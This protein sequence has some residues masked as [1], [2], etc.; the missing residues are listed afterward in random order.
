MDRLITNDQFD[1]FRNIGQFV[2]TEIVEGR[3]ETRV[4]EEG[5]KEN[6]GNF[7]FQRATI[8]VD[9]RW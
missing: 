7:L 6:A 2:V 5:F 8:E 3:K 4:E 9:F 1:D